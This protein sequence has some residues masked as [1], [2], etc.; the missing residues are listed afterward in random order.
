MVQKI[1]F[2]LVLVSAII[3]TGC[4]TSG[5][6]EPSGRLVFEREED[7]NS[8][9]YVMNIDG[10]GMTRLTDDPGWDGVPSW[11]PDGTRIA[12]ASERQG[13]PVIFVMDAD[14][15]N[16]HAITD[17]SYVSLAPVWSPD[18]SRIA[19][20][21]T[22]GYEVLRQGGRQQVEAGFELWLMNPDGSD[23]QRLTGYPEDQALYPTWAPDGEQLAYMNIG[24]A[25][26]I[27]AQEPDETAAPTVLS[28]GVD[29]RHWTPA[30]SPKG[31]QIAMMVE[32]EGSKDIW[33]IQPDGGEA[34]QITETSSSDIDPAWSPDGKHIVFV[35]DRDGSQL[36]YIMNVEDRTIRQ[37]VDDDST[38]AQPDWTGN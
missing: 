36:L 25:A 8:D 30:W 35:S 13:A 18:G 12:F 19:F 16:Q 28:E 14:G 17:P 20:A 6:S 7:G 22:A 9:I 2:I 23:P 10:S 1:G 33:L 5:R 21:S 34:V 32:N 29:G 3:L 15:S 38:Y 27:L 4:S 31:D 26:R 37:L 24:D 11:S